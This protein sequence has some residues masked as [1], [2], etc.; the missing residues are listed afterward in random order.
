[1]IMNRR[2]QQLRT[3]NRI[4]LASFLGVLLAVVL[5]IL[6]VDNLLIS[7][8]LAFVISYLL[9]PFVN[10]FERLGI[11]RIVAAAITFLFVGGLL[12]VAISS[13]LPLIA[14]QLGLLK[15]EFPKYVQGLTKL[16]SESEERI[17]AITGSY[18]AIDLSAQA[19][20]V[21]SPW[22]T[23]IFEDLPSFVTRSVTTLLLAPFLAFF[24]I[25]D[26]KIISRDLMNI[27]PNSI[28]ET[29]LSLYHQ[30]NDQMGH[31]VRARLLEAVFVGAFTWIGL[32]IINF[33]YATILALFAALT[34]LIPYVGPIIGAVPAI[35]IALINGDTTFGLFLVS[36]VYFTVQLVDAALIIPLVVA[37]IV[38]LHPIT[39]IISIIAG[40]QLLGV[41]GMLISIP[42]ASIIKVTVSTVYRH[43]TQNRA[44]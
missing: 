15:V 24:M 31:F 35:A 29:T 44:F 23:A 14:S 4:K 27:V 1:M 12:G 30:I 19:E 40:A 9:G 34:N 8:L 37:K 28:F 33:P 41:V 10:Y 3:L 13:L 26:G 5:T 32:F 16:L 6:N 18:F 38:D 42:V 11:N 39:V 21:L 20:A 17:E 25:K 2:R 7:F 43:L 22:T 36:A